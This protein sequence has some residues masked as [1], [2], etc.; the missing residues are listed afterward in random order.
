MRAGELTSRITIQR[1]AD[2]E[3]ER[4]QPLTTWTDVATVWATI[5]FTSGLGAIKAEAPVSVVK[6]SIRIRYRMGIA[7]GMRVLEGAAAYQVRAVLP[8][9]AGRDYVDLVCEIVT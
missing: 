7:A 1:P 9:R 6:A 8:D 5:A 2:G 4:G 3:D